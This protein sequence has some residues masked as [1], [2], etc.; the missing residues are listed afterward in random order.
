MA[1]LAR[2]LQDTGRQAEQSIQTEYYRLKPALDFM[3]L[4]FLENPSLTALAHKAGLAPNY[5]HR[6]FRALFGATPF[7]YMLAQRLNR[8]RHLLAST[9]LSIKEIANAVG[10]EDS[11]YFSRVFTAQMQISPSDYRATNLWRSR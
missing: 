1:I 11:S 3:Q 8:A 7:N 9:P 10:Y 6:R 5:F 4:H 2:L